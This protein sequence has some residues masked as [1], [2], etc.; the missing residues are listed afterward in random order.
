MKS[1][2]QPRIDGQHMGDDQ[3]RNQIQSKFLK[4]LVNFYSINNSPIFRSDAQR[5]KTFE[6]WKRS[7]DKNWMF[8]LTKNG[9]GDFLNEF[10]S[11]LRETTAQLNN[12]MQ[13]LFSLFWSFLNHFFSHFSNRPN[14]SKVSVFRIYLEKFS[15]SSKLISSGK[16]SQAGS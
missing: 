6:S 8:F 3:N 2:I 9:L 10:L 14:I 7:W 15:F 13:N 1:R 16:R 5:E 12:E 4:F 11:K